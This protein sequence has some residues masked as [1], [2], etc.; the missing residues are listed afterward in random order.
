ML[1]DLSQ[2]GEIIGDLFAAAQ[3]APLGESTLVRT[4]RCYAS[5]QGADP[6]A[7]E[8]PRVGSSDQPAGTGEI[9]FKKGYRA[10]D[11]RGNTS[12]RVD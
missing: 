2:R 3:A 4:W 10:L 8:D 12:A 7:A 5:E 1:L 6:R 9:D 11:D